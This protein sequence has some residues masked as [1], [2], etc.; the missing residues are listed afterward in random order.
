MPAADQ[1][2]LVV[3]AAI[4]AAVAGVAVVVAPS[5]IPVLGVSAA[6]FTALLLILKA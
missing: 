4:G 2:L 1:T 6:V 3:V 5:L